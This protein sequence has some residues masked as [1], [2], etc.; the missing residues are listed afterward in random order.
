MIKIRKAR[1][2]DIGEIVKIWRKDLIDY[3]NN[4]PTHPVVEE[5]WKFVP[6]ADKLFGE[7]LKEILNSEGF[8]LLVAEERGKVVGY[9]KLKIK[10]RWK[11]FKEKKEI[12]I[13]DIAV[14]ENC[15][16][17]G[18]GSKLLNE[19]EKYAKGENI[20]FLTLKADS[21]NLKT[22]R[23]YKKHGFVKHYVQMVKKVGE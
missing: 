10:N 1:E 14:I 4:L 13:N 18:I 3:H 15:R 22:L 8:I 7:H 21:E 11:A 9:T 12:Y 23:F 20:G 17:K 2:G 6:G 5:Y 16:G 19:T